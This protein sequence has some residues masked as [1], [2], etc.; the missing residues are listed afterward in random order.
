MFSTE[1]DVVTF[2]VDHTSIAEGR[3]RNSIR[4]ATKK[5]YTHGLV[6][7]DIVHMPGTVCGHWSTL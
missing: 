2:G 7:A 6:V 5:R 1:N 4:I 3:G